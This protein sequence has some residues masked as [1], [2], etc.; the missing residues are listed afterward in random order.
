[1]SNKLDRAQERLALLAGRQHGVVSSAQLSG[2]G[3]SRATVTAWVRRGRLHRLHRGVYAV[4]HAAPSEYQRFMAAAMAC[5]GGAV[6]S[7]Q[8][9]AYLW[10][11]L[12]PEEGPVHVTSPSRSGKRRRSGIVLHTSPSLA[13]GGERTRR[14]LIPVTTP[15]R[16]IEDLERAIEP[17]LWRRAK[18]QAEF[19]KYRLR[20]PTDRSRSDL[21]GDFLR[22]LARHGFP[23]PQ[24]NVKVGKYTVDFLWPAQML[25]VETD[26]FAYHR[27]HQAFEEDHER[28]LYLRRAGYVVRRYTGA[29]LDNYPAEIAAEL[30]EVL[31]RT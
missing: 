1:M 14:E 6:I 13:K 8:S 25:A 22:F 11:F 20:L 23:R 3:I 21:E 12:K 17:Y 24:V 10:R 26:F 18:R 19:M 15:R 27:G 29:Q 2:L 31:G 28:E 9:A 7:H 30:G 4:G 16:T 5:G